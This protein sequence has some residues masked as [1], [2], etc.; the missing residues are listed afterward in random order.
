MVFGVN[1]GE[2]DTSTQ[3]IVDIGVSARYSQPLPLD[4]AW[5]EK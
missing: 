3:A 5:K 4:T 1:A 2:G